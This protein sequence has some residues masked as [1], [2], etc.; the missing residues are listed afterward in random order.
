M[1]KSWEKTVEYK[2]IIDANSAGL[3]ENVTPL[4]GNAEQ[5]MA[6]A[7]FLNSAYFVLI[8]F[9]YC[10]KGFTRDYEEKWASELNVKEIGEF[11]STIH[12]P[13]PYYFVFFH[14]E[15]NHQPKLHTVKYFSQEDTEDEPLGIL[16][17]SDKYGLK[18]DDFI[19]FMT[20][21]ALYRKGSGVSSGG[22]GMIYG[23]SNEGKITGSFSETEFMEIINRKLMPP[24]PPPPAS[25]PSPS[26][27]P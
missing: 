1:S 25:S 13:T 8:E 2:F 20:N 4:D 5:A 21:M 15:Q 12:K 17:H 7:I 22:G 10:N 23:I 26:P 16:K 27:S 6:D 11:L 19:D 3:F 18:K 24:A 14:L 9:K